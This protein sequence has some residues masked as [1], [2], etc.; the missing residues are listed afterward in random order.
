MIFRSSMILD[1][2]SR[3]SFGRACFVLLP[4]EADFFLW[5]I[6]FEKACDWR[7]IHGRW[8]TSSMVVKVLFCCHLLSAEH[9][10]CCAVL[11]RV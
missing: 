8:V 7:K 3:A 11:W 9:R 1:G 4:Y 10:E 5:M 6:Y 2:P